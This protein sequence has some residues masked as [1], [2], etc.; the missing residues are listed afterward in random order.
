MR[1][2]AKLWTKIT[3]GTKPPSE[4]EGKRGRAFE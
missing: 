3:Q 1:S 4:K 2:I